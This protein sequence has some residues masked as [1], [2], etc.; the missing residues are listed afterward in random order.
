MRKCANFSP[1]Q[2]RPLVIYDFAPNPSLVPYI[3]GKFYFL[4]L[5]VQRYKM[6]Y[7]KLQINC[8][9]TVEILV[10]WWTVIQKVFGLPFIRAK[11][12]TK[13]TLHIRMRFLRVLASSW[14]IPKWIIRKYLK[15]STRT[16]YRGTTG[17]RRHEKNKLERGGTCLCREGFI[18]LPCNN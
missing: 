6:F 18:F 3:W 14:Y 17:H 9:W 7:K 1:Y 16:D 8:R 11:T 4:F 2:G 12:A 15:H 5:S 13:F 10:L